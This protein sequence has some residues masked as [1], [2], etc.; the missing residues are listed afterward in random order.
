MWRVHGSTPS[1]KIQR[2]IE[3]Q[4]CVGSKSL[5]DIHTQEGQETPFSQLASGQS[6]RVAIDDFCVGERSANV[7]ILLGSFKPRK[8]PKS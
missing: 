3:S 4:A 8:M 5:R 1:R 6:A 7:A 2:S